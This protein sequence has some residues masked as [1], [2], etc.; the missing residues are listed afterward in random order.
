MSAV[1]Q[2]ELLEFRRMGI[3]DTDAVRQIAAY[4]PAYLLRSPN[5]KRAAWDDL[6]FAC[7]VAGRELP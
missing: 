7:R 5:Q 3:D 2:S 6:Q 1:L 4:H